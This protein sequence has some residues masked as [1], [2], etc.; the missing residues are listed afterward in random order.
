MA[1]SPHRVA[2]VGAGLSGLRC[3]DILAEKGF[4]VTI[5]EGRNR[6]GGRVHQTQLANGRFVDMGPNWI[7]GTNG[8]TILDFAQATNTG[9][10]SPDESSSLFDEHGIRF[11]AKEGEKY[12]TM[13]WDIIEE[14][15]EYSKRYGSE[16]DASKS[17]L[18]YFHE[19]IPER[20]PESEFEYEKRRKV[21][22]Q[23]CQSWG[24]FI[25]TRIGRQ[26]LR[27]FWMEQCI[28]GGSSSYHETC[29]KVAN[30]TVY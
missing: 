15:F 1:Q 13:M 27:F 20:I 11:P 28:E 5:F 19:K 18:D 6:I 10:A 14:A 7:H 4:K 30:Q 25:G 21:L 26:S 3:A 9:T 29:A 17:L 23:L 12:E 24:A 16:I 22:L 8:N 2:I